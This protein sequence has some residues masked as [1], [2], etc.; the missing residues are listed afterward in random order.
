[1]TQIIGWLSSVV[2]VLTLTKQVYKQWDEGSSKNVS[3]WLFIGEMVSSV[4]FIVYSV[5]LQNWVFII[6]NILIFFSAVAG[7]L[8][9]L[10]HRQREKHQ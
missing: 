3:K 8:I 2:L 4:G 10:K 5:L 7:G 1:M 6:T 9:V